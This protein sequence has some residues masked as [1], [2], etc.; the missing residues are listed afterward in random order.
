[1]L[2]A[3]CSRFRA[4]GQTSFSF[5]QKGE[6]VVNEQLEGI[7]DDKR[8]FRGSY[9]RNSFSKFTSWHTRLTN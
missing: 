9:W 4:A 2:A 8:R 3:H 1:M 5:N 6:F 7:Q